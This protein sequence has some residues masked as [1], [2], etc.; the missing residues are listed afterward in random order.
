MMNDFTNRIQVMFPAIVN[1]VEG[2]T[3]DE[4]EAAT[5]VA[6]SALWKNVS[7]KVA[8]KTAKILA[9]LD[10]ITIDVQTDLQVVNPDALPVVQVEV[11]D[12]MGQA[13]VDT[14]SWD[15]SS[16]TSH[17]ANVQM[18]R[19]SRP[20]KLT[21][22][23]L[24]NGER[25]ESK[26]I[27]A[28]EVVAQG[29]IAQLASAIASVEETTLSEFGPEQAAEISGAFDSKETNALILSPSAYSKIV[30]TSGFALNPAVDGTYGINTIR[31]GTG[32]GDALALTKDAIAGAVCTPAVLSNHGG[33]MDVRMIGSVHGFPMLLKTAYD[34]D[35]V[36]K[37]SVEVMAGF[38]VANAAGVKRYKIS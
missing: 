2:L 33:N 16:V 34:F 21:C 17:Y 25:V 5:G 26:I 29:V 7:E 23:D 22:Y 3:N 30:P 4:N 11:I 13:L 36:L 24:Q 9:P 6:T 37:C 18:H 28:A 10:G 32:L 20:F 19:I 1:K 31:K 14:A 38:V 15:A 12:E 35:E 8:D 27:A